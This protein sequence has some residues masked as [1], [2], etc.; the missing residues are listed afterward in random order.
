MDVLIERCAGLDVHR[1]TVVA[2]VRRPG[3]GGA[4]RSQ[5][6]GVFDD[7]R[8]AGRPGGLAGFR[9][10]DLGRDGIDPRY[11]GFGQIFAAF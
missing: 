3:P 11:P 9:E 2:T 1:D 8:C 5:T 4:R 10:S 6:R 7:D